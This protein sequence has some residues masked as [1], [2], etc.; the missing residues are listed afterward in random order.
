KKTITLTN[1]VLLNLP[2]TGTGRIFIAKPDINTRPYQTRTDTDA[3]QQRLLTFIHAHSASL[4]ISGKDHYQ[5]LLPGKVISLSQTAVFLREH[6]AKIALGDGVGNFSSKL[7]LRAT[8]LGFAGGYPLSHAYIDKDFLG[9]HLDVYLKFFSGRIGFHSL[10]NSPNSVYDQL[11]AEYGL[12]GLLAFAIYYVGFFARHV[13]KLTYGLSILIMVT[14]V[15]F[16]DYW[17]EQLS[18]LV[19]FEMLLLLNIKETNFLKPANYG[20]NQA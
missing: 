7:A 10:I 8:G 16:I 12:L 15:F 4:P 18:V 17:F 13:K 2:I 1:Q 9:N 5:A 14:A 19:F 3:E 20:I 11:L 6:P